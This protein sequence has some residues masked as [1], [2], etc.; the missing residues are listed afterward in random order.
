MA[1]QWN[2]KQSQSDSSVVFIPGR[3]GEEVD[4]DLREKLQQKVSAD[5]NSVNDDPPLNGWSSTF[6][7]RMT[8]TS[9]I[10]S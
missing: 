8:I 3:V 9:V 2:W 1:S 10:T 7:L 6:P 4:A 5:L